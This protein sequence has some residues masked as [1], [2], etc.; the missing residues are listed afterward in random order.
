MR[1]VFSNLVEL[2]LSY[3]TIDNELDLIIW[4]E[5]IS[6]QLI[7][8]TGNPLASKEEKHYSKL[9]D[10]LNKNISCHLRIELSEHPLTFRSRMDKEINRIKLNHSLSLPSLNQTNIKSSFVSTKSKNNMKS[11]HNSE[12]FAN[13]PRPAIIKT[14]EVGN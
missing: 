4:T 3:N 12:L 14:K 6:I 8:I 5:L 2:D 1:D 10:K 11:R 7:D 13:Y 9:K